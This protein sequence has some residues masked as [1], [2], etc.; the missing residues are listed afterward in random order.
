MRQSLDRGAQSVSIGKSIGMLMRKEIIYM[1]NH[2]V[3]MATFL[4]EVS[5]KDLY[6]NT[7]FKPVFVMQAML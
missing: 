5:C 1:V 7:C 4:S 6:S 2:P 3:L